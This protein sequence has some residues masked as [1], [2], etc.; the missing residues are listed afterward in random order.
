MM[1]SVDARLF[2]SGLSLI[3]RSATSIPQS[4]LR[5]LL[6]Y[7]VS[8]GLFFFLYSTVMGRRTDSLHYRGWTMMNGL[9]ERDIRYTV[10]S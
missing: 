4:L 5:I 2:R 1:D 9:R 8:I 10:M 6:L 3:G 7:I